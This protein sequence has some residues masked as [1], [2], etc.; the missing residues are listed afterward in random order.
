MPLNLKLQW[1]M[2]FPAHLLIRTVQRTYSRNQP[3]GLYE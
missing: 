3:V 1:G 2:P